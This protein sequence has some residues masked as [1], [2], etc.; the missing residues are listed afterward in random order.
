MQFDNSA[1]SIANSDLED[2]EVQKMLTS[3]LYCQNATEK[4]DAMVI[5]EGETG[6]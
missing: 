5:Q 1:E 3:P 2:G 4:P 6:K